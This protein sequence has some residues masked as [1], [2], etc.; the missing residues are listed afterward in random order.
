MAAIETKTGPGQDAADQAQC[1]SPTINRPRG[2]SS[3]SKRM[4]S[5]TQ[6]FEESNPPG[7]F[8]AA[9]GD[10]ASTIYS[11]A[12]SKQPSWK[13]AAGTS[14]P[15]RDNSAQG[16]SVASNA[17]EPAGAAP[18]P[19]GYHFPPKH[20][21]GQSTKE[22]LVAFWKFFT[23]PF[24]FCLTIYGLNIVAWGGMLFLLLCNAGEH[25][26]H[27]LYIRGLSSS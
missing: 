19:N 18:F 12:A 4:R 13:V 6:S 24:G 7:G 21:F 14:G 22:G 27:V 26:P 16:G 2:Q 1:P 9:T 25:S 17:E 11:Q 8:S 15:V 10:M 23:T 20:S 3:L 5:V